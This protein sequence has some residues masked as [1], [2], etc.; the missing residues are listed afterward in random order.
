ML[1]ELKQFTD[2]LSYEKQVSSHTL[3]AY[4]NDLSAMVRSIT[5]PPGSP[6]SW[7]RVTPKHIAWYLVDLRNQDY[8]PRTRNRKIESAKS[9]FRFLAEEKII[10]TNPIEN[11]GT[12]PGGHEPPIPKALSVDEV[13]QLLAVERDCPED[14][15][16][17]V[18]VELAY[19]SGLRVS[20][21]VGLQI[22]DVD[23]DTATV[24]TIGKNH[25]ARIIPLYDSA[26]LAVEFYLEMVRPI[27]T[28][29][30]SHQTLFLNRRGQQM[31]RQA[32]WLRLRKLADKAGIA[33]GKLS[34]HVLRHSFATHLLHG[35]A[36]LIHVQ[37]LLGHASVETTQVYT[38]LTSDYVRNQYD[39]AHP[40]S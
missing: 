18:M 10:Q 15:R 20:E 1:R 2:Y 38:K 21:L 29:N 19:A 39:S 8:K 23:L 34:P 12:P 13:E 36:S 24:R 9:F 4:R 26:I 17:W 14:E 6:R 5:M 40:R 7:A 27:H 3:A 30:K 31:S 35:G 37:E 22:R 28:N 25:K 32:F 11:V 16:D 33:Q